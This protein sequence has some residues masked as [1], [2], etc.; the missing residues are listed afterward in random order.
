VLDEVLEALEGLEQRVGLHDAVLDL[1]VGLDRLSNQR[2]RSHT[3]WTN[4]TERRVSVC[5]RERVSDSE[6]E[7]GGQVSEALEGLEQRVGLHD[8]LLD[9]RVG[10][11]RL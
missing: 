2:V 9:L 6:R 4:K 8:A 1:R 7:R 11:D 10:L 3:T 5:V